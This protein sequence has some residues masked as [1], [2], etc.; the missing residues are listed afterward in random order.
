VAV[1]DE[2][3]LSWLAGQ[4]LAVVGHRQRPHGRRH[5][6]DV[7]KLTADEQAVLE[8][9]QAQNGPALGGPDDQVAIHEERRR[10]GRAA[11]GPA[12]SDA[13]GEQVEREVLAD[14]GH[15]VQLHRGPM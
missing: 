3:E 8:P 9:R 4:R 14:C 12:R 2:R 10:I 5:L 6:R 7:R 15:R 13:A 1:A 11:H